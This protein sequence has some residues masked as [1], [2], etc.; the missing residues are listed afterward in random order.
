MAFSHAQA[1]ATNVANG[2]S[3]TL[4]VT[5]TNN[6][7]LG[8]LV[9][10]G[11]TWFDGSAGLPASLTV[12]DSNGNVY[13]PTPNSPTGFNAMAQNYIFYLLDAPANASKTITATYTDPGAGGATIM[14]VDD[15]A[16]S[17]GK[18][19]LDTDSTG[20]G[21][22]TTAINSPTVVRNGNSELLFS[23][24]V[25]EFGVTSVN[26]PWTQ[27]AIDADGNATGYILSS[28][29]NVAVAATQNSGDWSCIAASF[30]EVTSGTMGTSRPP[31]LRPRIFAPGI[32]R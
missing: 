12:Q 16:L 28:S 4:T 3:T 25:S 29:A 27:G 10:V 7:G 14:D 1:T 11:F 22:G 2:A 26:A 17:A 32:A 18:A 19:L 20:S 13:V 24:Y 23:Y 21:T 30:F 8:D 9:C 15:F 6:P 5:L 31:K